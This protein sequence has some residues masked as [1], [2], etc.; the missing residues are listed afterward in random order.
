MNQDALTG[1]AGIALA[2]QQIRGILKTVRAAPGTPLHQIMCIAHQAERD[3]L[4]V[5]SPLWRALGEY[6][7]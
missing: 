2:L 7:K 6:Q 3:H 4:H 1:A 5:G